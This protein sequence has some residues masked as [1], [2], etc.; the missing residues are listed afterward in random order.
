M[1]TIC[2]MCPMG[3][4]IE[5]NKIEDKITVT[6]HTCKRGETYGIQ[7]YSAPKRV[8][9]SLVKVIGGG[10]ISVK[11][12]DLVDKSKIFDIL[13][14]LKDIKV[15]APVYVGD[16]II[17]NVLNTGVDIVATREAYE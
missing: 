8:V 2:I 13:D 12:N 6:G 4:P 5:V 14:T 3:C 16:V 15:S 9:T 17:K 10:V 7:E 1:K 11:T